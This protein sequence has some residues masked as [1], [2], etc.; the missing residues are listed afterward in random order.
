MMPDT[1]FAWP[2]LANLD[3]NVFHDLWATV[4]EAPDCFCH[5]FPRYDCFQNPGSYR[6]SSEGFQPEALADARQKAAQIP[7]LALCFSPPGVI[8][9]RPIC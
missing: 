8:L 2:R 5:Y 7:V 6:Q 3:I 9:A 4:L 1:R